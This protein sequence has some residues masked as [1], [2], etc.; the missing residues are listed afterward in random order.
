MVTV[1]NANIVLVGNFN[2]YIISPEWLSEEGVWSCDEIHFALGAIKRDGVQFRGGGVQWFVSSE[3]MEIASQEA[4]CGALAE[5]VLE[6]LPH[7]PMLAVG[8]NFGIQC[9]AIA[10]ASVFES[11]SKLLP[12]LSTETTR[13]VATMHD[14]GVR[15]EVTFVNGSEGT[16]AAVNFHRITRSAA[17]AREAVRNFSSDKERALQ[18]ISS[19][20]KGED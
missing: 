5:R 12:D 2:P 17:K 15:I 7:T 19:I 6:R 9:D 20:S 1:E 14:N 18:L 10:A 11:I 4:D 16:S 13:W 3:R 8:D